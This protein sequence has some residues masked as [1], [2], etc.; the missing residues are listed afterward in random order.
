MLPMIQSLKQAGRTTPLALQNV[1]PVLF[2]LMPRSASLPSSHPIPAS[3]PSSSS[4]RRRGREGRGGKIN[5]TH[6]DPVPRATSSP[7]TETTQTHWQSMQSQHHSTVP[8]LSLSPL[9]LI[10]PPSIHTAN[11]GCLPFEM[12]SPYALILKQSHVAIVTHRAPGPGWQEGSVW[13]F[14]F[15]CSSNWCGTVQ[16][17]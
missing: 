4:S 8:L 12:L 15:V 9:P 5:P 3:I 16:P 17:S 1:L 2:P 10:L 14:V 6:T 13:F 7:A 11:C